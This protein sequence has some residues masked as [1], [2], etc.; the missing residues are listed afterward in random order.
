MSQFQANAP[1]D[2]VATARNWGLGSIFAD[3]DNDHRDDLYVCND[4]DGADYF[5][6][7]TANGFDDVISGLNNMTSAFSMGVDVAD[8]NNDGLSDFIVVDM[9]NYSLH[10][11]KMQ[12]PH[13]T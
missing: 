7:S 8:I 13:S 11:R 4:L 2:E 9:L 1:G 3:F 10:E 6:R 5:Y 12:I